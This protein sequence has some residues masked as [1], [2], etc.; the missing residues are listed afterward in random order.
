MTV[1]KD[2]KLATAWEADFDPCKYPFLASDVIR[3]NA[4]EQ[5]ALALAEITSD[6]ENDASREAVIVVR[7][8]GDLSCTLEATINA[9]HNSDLIK[10]EKS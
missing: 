4:M 1:N 10:K 2:I 5:T 7:S 3:S 6:G 9:W 8:E